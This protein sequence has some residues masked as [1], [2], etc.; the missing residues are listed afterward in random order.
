MQEY[1]E[2]YKKK[3]KAD[4]KNDYKNDW[5][6]VSTPEEQG[7]PSIAIVHFLEQIRARD[8]EL[9]VSRIIRNGSHMH[10]CG[11]ST[12]SLGQLSPDLFS[13]EGD[14][15]DSHVVRNPG[16]IFSDGRSCDSTASVGVDSG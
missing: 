4:C 10:Q 13:G 16:R 11:G 12:L 8:L 3:S 5:I 1:R 15:G 6:P 14:R 2:E 7:I 9:T